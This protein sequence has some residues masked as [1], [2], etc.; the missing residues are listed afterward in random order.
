M[1]QNHSALRAR[2]RW[3]AHAP[4][5]TESGRP[6]RMRLAARLTSRSCTRQRRAENALLKRHVWSYRIM[7]T[8]PV[9]VS[10]SGLATS[11]TRGLL[12]KLLL[13][14]WP[15]F[16][17]AGAGAIVHAADVGAYVTQATTTNVPPYGPEGIKQASGLSHRRAASPSFWT[18]SGTGG[19][20][21]SLVSFQRM[22]A[23]WCASGLSCWRS[24]GGLPASPL[25][26][27]GSRCGGIRG[28]LMTHGAARR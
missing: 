28:G 15:A 22:V 23:G 12:V 24:P 14:S 3:L 5:R 21:R 11:I 9:S 1:R 16:G 18:M 4:G 10:G 26:G 2:S 7:L 20:T 19:M 17:L 27:G 13:V 6:T 25:L 8:D